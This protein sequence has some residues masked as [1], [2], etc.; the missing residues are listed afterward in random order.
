MIMSAFLRSYRPF[1][2]RTIIMETIEYI[3]WADPPLRKATLA[4]L[5][6]LW[7]VSFAIMGEGFPHPISG[8]LAITAFVLAI[9]VSIVLL[10]I[11]WLTPEL[12]LYS[13]FPFIFLYMFDEISTSYKTPLILLCALFLTTGIVGYQLSLNKDSL[14]LGWL[15][16]LLVAIATWFFASHAV[17]NY[18]Q[19]TSDL[20]YVDCMPDFQGCA[21]LTG[22]ETPWWVLFLSL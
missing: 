6:P 7:L 20:G 11:R 22:N 17:Q 10:W 12:L 15:I 8:R 9:A 16:L 19:M 3:R 5:L 4:N 14:G 2:K 1:S 13:F 21:P 18:W